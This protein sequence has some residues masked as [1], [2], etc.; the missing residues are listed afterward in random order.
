MEV[1][2]PL[3]PSKEGTWRTGSGGDEGNGSK[4]RPST[5]PLREWPRTP[6]T[7][8]LGPA[9]LPALGPA[10]SPLARGGAPPPT[11]ALRRR[12]A[13]LRHLDPKVMAVKN[14]FVQDAHCIPGISPPVETD[15]SKTA[16]FAGGWV[17][18]KEDVAGPAVLL[19]HVPSCAAK[20]IKPS[21]GSSRLVLG[22][23]G[24][25]KGIRPDDCRERG[26]ALVTISKFSMKRYETKLT[27]RC[28][29]EF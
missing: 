29:V 7:K 24:G 27:G 26:R 10:P 14:P 19:E 8:G 16:A 4:R 5:K 25:G 11:Q 17:S 23:D 2:L 20:G 12:S 22:Q 28:L 6:T 3:K 18:W 15:E 1:A 9:P 13:V 21:E